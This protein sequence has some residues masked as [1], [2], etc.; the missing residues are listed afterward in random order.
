[1]EKILVA[2]DS[3]RP[4]SFAGIHALNLAKRISATV[5]FLLIFP[6]APDSA[7]S[8]TEKDNQAFV[9]KNVH[10]LLE[11]ARSEG[12]AVDYYFAYGNYENELV[13]FVQEKNVTLLIVEN[14]D[15]QS[16]S[17]AV[18][19]KFLNK[20]RHR[21]NCRIEVVHKKPNHPERKE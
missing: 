17:T 18:P 8:R 14:T 10:A 15:S 11:Q 19:R 3:L 13:N 2:M 5:S 6:A 20:L 1:M 21:I 4:H 7:G 9:K 16:E 12:I